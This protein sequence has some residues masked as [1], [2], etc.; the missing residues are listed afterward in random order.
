VV[1][2]A[3][4]YGCGEFGSHY[5]KTERTARKTYMVSCRSS[6]DGYTDC[7]QAT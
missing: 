4:F 1:G 2:G 6:W 5:M 7:I 3:Y